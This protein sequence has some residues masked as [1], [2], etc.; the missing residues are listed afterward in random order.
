MRKS[1]TQPPRPMK[2]NPP[3]YVEIQ[4]P[5]DP[6][7]VKP[8]RSPCA[9]ITSNKCATAPPMA[10]RDATQ[11]AGDT[12]PTTENS[13]SPPLFPNPTVLDEVLEDYLRRADKMGWS[14]YDLVDHEKVKDLARVD[15]L[16][17]HQ[18]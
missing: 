17:E 10:N 11:P 5:R 13:S 6:S 9:I 12:P 16:T 7:D 15:R 14:P 18:L 4:D 2:R 1:T 8:P 3:T